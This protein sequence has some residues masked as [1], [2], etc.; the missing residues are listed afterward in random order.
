MFV[1]KVVLSLCLPS[2]HVHIACGMA[3]CSP[4]GDCIWLEGQNVVG[5]DGLVRRDIV[6]DMM[7]GQKSP[8]DC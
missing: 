7:Q 4:I 5:D 3:W 6:L 1:S 2:A 8:A